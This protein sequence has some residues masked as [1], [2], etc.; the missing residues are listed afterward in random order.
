[1]SQCRHC[2]TDC[3]T[4]KTHEYKKHSPEGYDHL[5]VKACIEK[6]RLPIT[7]G[8]RARLAAAQTDRCP[9][10]TCK[11]RCKDCKDCEAL[12]LEHRRRGFD[13]ACEAGIWLALRK[14]QGLGYNKLQT[15]EKIVLLKPPFLMVE[16]LTKHASHILCHISRTS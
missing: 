14:E 3:T 1:M 2:R 5:C 12:D 16:G 4:M 11:K 6:L 15:T 13:E 9:Q 10:E 7:A 8:H